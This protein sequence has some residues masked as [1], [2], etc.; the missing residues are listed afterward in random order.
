MPRGG[1]REG[2]GRKK[3]R[4]RDGGGRFKLEAAV[5][6]LT[7]LLMELARSG[8]FQAIKFAMTHAQQERLIRAQTRLIEVQVR[9]AE[10]AA[11]E[12]GGDPA[13]GYEDPAPVDPAPANPQTEGSGRDDQGQP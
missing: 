7:D 6:E 1:R 4:L 5:P 11:G 3:Q 8:D 9:R 10:R 13:E 2:A 12:I